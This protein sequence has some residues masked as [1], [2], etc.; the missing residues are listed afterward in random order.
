M[1]LN[2]LSLC[3]FVWGLSLLPTAE[4]NE[5]SD[6]YYHQPGLPAYP[7]RYNDVYPYYENPPFTYYYNFP[8]GGYYN[9]KF[10]QQP[11]AR[12]YYNYKMHKQYEDEYN[13]YI[14]GYQHYH[15]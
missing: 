4:G 10:R 7:H 2:K 3:F 11:R 8:Y 5:E 12:G 14:H 13:R 15:R 1:Y 6:R 9:N